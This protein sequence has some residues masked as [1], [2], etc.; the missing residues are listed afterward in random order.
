MN[1]K[2]TLT[3]SKIVCTLGPAS[4]EPGQIKRLS[5][6]GMDCARI[7]FSHGAIDDKIKLFNRIRDVDDRLAILCDIQGPKIRIGQVKEGGVLLKTGDPFT[8]TTEEVMGDEHKVSISYT[9]LAAEAQVGD[10]IFINDGIVCVQVEA[11]NG[12]HI[13]CQ[14]LSGGYISSRKG[15]N[16]PHTKIAL[17]VPTAKDSEDLKHIAD[18][19]PEFVAISFVSGAADVLRIR[20]LLAEYGNDRIKLIPKI[21]RPIA[22]ENF[23]AI[24]AVADG[25]MVARGDLGV[26]LPP[27][28]V[29]PVQKRMITRCN[30]IGKPVIVATQMLE[31]MV[32]SPVPTRA[33]VSDVFNAIEDGADAVM[34]SAETASGDYP[35]NAVEMMERVIRVSESLIPHRDPD[36]YDSSEQ[37][38]T[39]IIGHLVHATC[40]EFS[41]MGYEK[42]KIICET[43]SGYSVRMIAKYRPRLPIIGI[44]SNAKTAREMRLVW[45]VEPLIIPELEV[46][47][48]VKKRVKL[49][50]GTCLE[51]SLIEADEKIIISGNFLHLPTQS[52]MLS[53]L[54]ASD[55]LDMSV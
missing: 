29:L 21:E 20:K 31:S 30:I 4:S 23:D 13:E 27:E 7:N 48:E 14:V 47:D 1:L 2:K 24:L 43:D 49:A 19:D 18:L 50:I 45:G 9:Q 10:K 44:T 11:V 28:E 41:D 12:P 3:Q 33:E 55:I 8:I 36:Q 51:R 25:I 26:E 34:L 16:L 40:K 42:G 5:D 53:V 46:V 54:L 37:T 39:E 22:V 32:K 17:S 52:N 15:V 38:V 35:T 6:L